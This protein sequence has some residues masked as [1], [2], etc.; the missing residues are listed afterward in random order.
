MSIMCCISVEDSARS[1]TSFAKASRKWQPEELRL[2]D[3][4]TSLGSKLQP[5]ARYCQQ[6]EG[7]EVS[8][9]TA[10]GNPHGTPKD[11]TRRGTRCDPEDWKCHPDQAEADMISKHRSVTCNLWEPEELHHKSER[12][13]HL[14]L[15]RGWCLEEGRTAP[16]VNAMAGNVLRLGPCGTG[17]SQVIKE[18]RTSAHSETM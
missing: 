15:L 4:V 17:G 12:D 10:H 1:T 2:E 18:D 6:R 9:E 11:V 16:K 5:N 14:A 13:A 8:S 7:E 3:Y